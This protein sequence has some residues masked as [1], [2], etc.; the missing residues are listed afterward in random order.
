[1]T[2]AIRAS[3]GAGLL[4]STQGPPSGYTAPSTAALSSTGAEGTVMVRTAPR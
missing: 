3:A 2:L 4:A 1:M